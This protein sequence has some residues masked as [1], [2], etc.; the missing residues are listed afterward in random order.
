MERAFCRFTDRFTLCVRGTPRAIGE[1]T[2]VV[3]DSRTKQPTP[4]PF[5]QRGGAG[6]K[7]DKQRGVKRERCSLGFCADRG[8]RRGRSRPGA[9]REDEAAAANYKLGGA[10]VGVS[11]LD[12]ETGGRCDIRASEPFTP[13][14][15]MK[16]LTRGRP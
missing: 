6:G 14:S 12:L 1:L 16:L 4:H 11:V 3:L 15:N 5:P 9:E 13:A 8:G 7:E 10:K 2:W